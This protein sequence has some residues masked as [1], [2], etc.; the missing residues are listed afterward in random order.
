MLACSQTLYFLFKVP[1]AGVIKN[2]NREGFTYRQRKG[3]GVGALAD[4]RKERK[5]KTKSV[6][7]QPKYQKVPCDRNIR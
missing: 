7:R 3:V 5:E 2:E 6:Y 4:Y 1:R